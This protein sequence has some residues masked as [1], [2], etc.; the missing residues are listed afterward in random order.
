[1]LTRT[2]SSFKTVKKTGGGSTHYCVLGD[3]TVKTGRYVENIKRDLIPPS[4]GKNSSCIMKTDVAGSSET[5]VFST[6]RHGVISRKTQ[7]WSDHR[8][9]TADVCTMN[10]TVFRTKQSDRERR[11]STVTPKG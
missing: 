10:S 6:N 5:L 7:Q 4:P 2:H 8:Q 3:E 9:A 11:N 1:M